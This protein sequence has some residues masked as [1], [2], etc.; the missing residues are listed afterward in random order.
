MKHDREKEL[1][2]Q[3]PEQADTAATPG[4][5][6]TAAEATIDAEFEPVDQ[7]DV[8]APDETEGDASE[9]VAAD[10]GT[11]KGKIRLPALRDAATN[12]LRKLVPAEEENVNLPAWVEWSRD[13]FFPEDVI[14]A[15]DERSFMNTSGLVRK[16]NI[17]LGVFVI[18]ALLWAAVVPLDSAIIAHGEVVVKTHRKTIQHLEG[19]IV[20]EIKVADGQTV[21]AGQVLVVL[22]DAQAK[23]NLGILRGEVD[24][25]TA[26]EARLTAERDGKDHV[27]FPPELKARSSDQTAAEA[28]RGEQ[29]AFVSR[30]AALEQ[31]VGV[32]GQRTGENWRMIAGLRNQLEA[33]QHQKQLVEQEV[34]SVDALYKQGLATLPRLLALQ[35]QAADLNGQEGQISEKIAQVKL[36][37]G[38]NTIQISRVRQEQLSQ[39]VQDLREVQTKRYQALD[40]LHAAEDMLK[41]TKMTSPVTGTVVSL[42]VHTVGAVI[43]PGETVM[44][45]VPRNDSM[46][47][48]AQIRPEDVDDLY[49]GIP[50]RI[51]FSAYKQRSLPLIMGKLETLSADRLTDPRTG[52]GYF[53][54][55]VSVNGDEL[56]D[57]PDVRLMPGLPVEVEIATG[58]R[59]ALQYLFSPITRAMRH[60]MRER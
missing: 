28:M 48:E 34:A 52:Q 9:E 5:E 46:E 41:H 32:L 15:E 30:K 59:T 43:K 47:I 18:G 58:S 40:R 12:L 36:S 42:S 29:E 50:A 45:V 33:V 3:S 26:Q 39:I 8:A 53:S 19:G 2:E 57:Y 55:M 1:T 16:G 23:A 17:V 54:I 27:E 20:R 51:N 44:E 35:R 56:K 25:L 14:D 10:A 24:S 6:E 22:D 49:V 7:A 13:R 21:K 37:S 38:E 4:P 60:G 31:Q 11:G